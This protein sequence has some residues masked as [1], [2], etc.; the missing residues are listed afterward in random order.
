MPSTSVIRGDFRGDFRRE[1]R[2]TNFSTQ[3]FSENTNTSSS[4]AR[5]LPL[6]TSF[7]ATIFFQPIHCD[8][9]HLLHARHLTLARAQLAVHAARPLTRTFIAEL[10]LVPK[11]CVAVVRQLCS[12]VPTP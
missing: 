5:G 10:A 9:L 7:S 11:Q 1:L 2:C 8:G 12:A 6:G 4:N 3:I